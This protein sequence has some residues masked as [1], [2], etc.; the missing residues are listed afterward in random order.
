MPAATASE[1]A[2]MPR[3]VREG[4]GV[5]VVVIGTL[6]RVT[7]WCL[8][9]PLRGRQGLDRSLSDRSSSAV[10]P[11]RATDGRSGNS[12]TRLSLPPIAAT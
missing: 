5:R 11:V 8:A 1:R 3:C 6:P 7:V 12:T 2:V 9:Q 4:Q 10:R